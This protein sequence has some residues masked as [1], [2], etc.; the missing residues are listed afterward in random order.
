MT[1]KTA[2]IFIIIAILLTAIVLARGYAEW[3]YVKTKTDA[4]DR[5]IVDP[6]SGGGGVYDRNRQQT[7]TT[8]EAW[9]RYYIAV[10]GG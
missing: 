4:Q 2:W 1:N 5:F 9:H 10:L 7:I 6:E 3:V 8:D